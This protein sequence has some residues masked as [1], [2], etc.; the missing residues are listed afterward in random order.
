MLGNSHFSFDNTLDLCHTCTMLTTQLFYRDGREFTGQP[1]TNDK[2][3]PVVYRQTKCGRCGG[4]GGSDKWKHTGWTCYQCGGHGKG[5]VVADKL[6]TAE[7]LV[8]MND[9]QAKRDAKKASERA[10]AD[11]KRKADQDARRAQ[12][13]IDNAE[14]LKLV[15]ELAKT[16]SFIGDI[17]HT[18]IDRAAI[19]ERQVEVIRNKQAEIARKAASAYI[20]EVGQRVDFICTLKTFRKFEGQYG[21]TYLHIM[22]TQDGQTVKY[23]GSNLLGGGE[24][25]KYGYSDYE[26]IPNGSSIEF[27]A[28]IKE[29][30]EYNGEKQTVVARPKLKEEPKTQ[31]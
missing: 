16:E 4:A 19:S 14:I 11:A 26:Y 17:L 28:T 24:W 21:S 5:P 25:K 20:G 29:H 13:L 15:E 9:A 3:K 7:Q 18:C 6:Y 31:D 22:H 8:K 10:A 30:T 12:F 27:K 1:E 23:M 2:G